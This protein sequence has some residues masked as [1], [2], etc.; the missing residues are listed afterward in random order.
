VPAAKQYRDQFLDQCLATVRFFEKE[1]AK[2]LR[3]RDMGATSAAAVDAA[4]IHL[5]LAR[6]DLANVEGRRQDAVEQLHRIIQIREDELGR[7]TRGCESRV[8]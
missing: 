1:L 7:A 2:E 8:G 3:L 4:Q 5:A 6:Y